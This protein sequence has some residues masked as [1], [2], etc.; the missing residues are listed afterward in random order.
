M[1][2]LLLHGVKKVYNINPEEIPQLRKINI[3]K[4]SKRRIE[5]KIWV[6]KDWVFVKNAIFVESMHCTNMKA[7]LK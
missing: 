4:Y 1:I 5:R 2:S 7:I 3:V 6:N